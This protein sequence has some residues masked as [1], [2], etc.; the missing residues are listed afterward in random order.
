M[1]TSTYG[2]LL[3]C[4]GTE[5]MPISVGD[6]EH[7][8]TLVGGWFDA[9]RNDFDPQDFASNIIHEDAE[10]FTVVG[11]VHD[12]GLLI[13]LPVNA[14]ASIVLGREIAG[15]CVLVSGTSPSGEYDGENHDVP[16]WFADA[17][18]QGGLHELSEA[19]H[20]EAE[21]QAKA[22]HLAIQDGVFTKEQASTIIRMMMSGDERYEEAI[23]KAMEISVTYALGRVADTIPKFDRDQFTNFQDSL[24]LTNEEIAKFWEENN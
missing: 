8:N 16:E 14:M 2:I 20:A 7:I 17:V 3:P 10:P 15:P 18:F 24:K 4:D 12:E 5:P 13:G 21:L 23:T 22:F 11:Y 9:V 19:L 6:H 1:T